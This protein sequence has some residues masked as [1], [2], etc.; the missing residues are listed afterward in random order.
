LDDL[1]K[2]YETYDNYAIVLVSGERTDFYLHNP[3]QTTLLKT[4]E[5]SLPNHHNKGGQS[6]PRFGRIHEEKIDWYIKK[7]IEM[8]EHLY[9]EHGK[10][11][12]KGI[13]IAGPSEMKNMV[14]KHELFI[15]SFGANLLKV[16]TI[17]EITDQSIFQVVRL[18]TDVLSNDADEKILLDI[19]EATLTNPNKLDLIVFGTKEV[20]ILF[21]AGQLKEIYVYEKY[22]GKEYILKSDSKTNVHVIRSSKFAQN[23]GD[24]VGILYY[25]DGVYMD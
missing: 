23:Y 3:N 7:I 11:N 18:A 20:M 2:L 9:L 12:H 4:I 10:F 14:K 6:A 19:F 22:N 5:E 15:K 8:M 17:S 1:I 13:V 24:L 16:L 21:D 25:N